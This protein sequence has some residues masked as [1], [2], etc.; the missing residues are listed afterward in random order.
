MLW[1]ANH[2]YHLLCSIKQFCCANHNTL[3]LFTVTRQFTT[4]EFN[5]NWRKGLET[6]SL[7]S[8]ISTPTDMRTP[9]TSNCRKVCLQSLGGGSK[10][11]NQLCRTPYAYSN[12][13]S[14][15]RQQI[16]ESLNGTQIRT[17]KTLAS[18]LGKNGTASNAT[19]R[20]SPTA[21]VSW[22]EAQL[23]Q[24]PLVTKALTGGLIAAG[25][26]FFCQTVLEE[27]EGDGQSALEAYDPS[28][29]FRFA[30]LGTCFVAPTNHIWY[31][32][33]AKHA[34]PGKTW[35]SAFKRTALDQFGWTRKLF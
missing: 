17:S 26:D 28:R 12:A 10:T 11:Q 27:P 20:W 16:Y 15:H 8:Y 6:N 24:Y 25:G 22:Y 29:T 18:K 33:L 31:R 35:S 1:C 4:T 9:C 13:T 34:A 7:T 5:L 30:F 2:T 19:S 23:T 14:S 21:F 32:F 3:L